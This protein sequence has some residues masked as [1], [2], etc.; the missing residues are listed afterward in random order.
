MT[1]TALY[2]RISTSKQEEENQLIQ[3]R[4]FAKKNNWEIFKEYM[5]IAISGK[6]NSR[7]AFDELFRDAHKKLFDIVLFWD[8][9]RFS[10]SGALFTLQKLQELKGLGIEWISYQEPYI[11]SIG[12]FSDVIISLLSTVAKIE[13]EKISMRTKAGL[14]RLKSQG[15][16]LGRP[17]GKKDKKKRKRKYFKKP[18]STNFII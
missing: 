3:L 15:V 10:R 7:P 17:K 6:E 14:E 12:Q 4:E 13:R 1:S 11:R 8:F 9:S 5:D 16:K 18:N 2:I